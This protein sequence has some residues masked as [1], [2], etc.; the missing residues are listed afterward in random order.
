[1]KFCDKR[2][3][4]GLS[5]NAIIIIII[6]II[7]FSIGM[8]LLFK[9]IDASEE[10]QDLLNQQIITAIESR[11]IQQNK[12]VALPFNSAVLEVGDS[13][14]FGIGYRNIQPEAAFSIAIS[15]SQGS[16]YHDGTP[17]TEVINIEEWFLW[18]KDQGIVEENA[19]ANSAIRVEVPLD[20]ESGNYIFN[21]EVKYNSGPYG[22]RQKIN[23]QVK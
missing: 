11:L 8:T 10:T 18:Q 21:V 23:I 20:A 4:I 16:T 17:I 15:F 2:G 9:F 3:A 7:L 5:V 22:K 19:I 12:L 14:V 6:S 1:M 13:K